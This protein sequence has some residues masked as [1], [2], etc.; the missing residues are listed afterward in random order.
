MIIVAILVI[1]IVIT[2]F[3]SGEKFFILQNTNLDSGN[4]SLETNIKRWEF[5]VRVMSDGKEVELIE[6]NT[7]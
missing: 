5:N 4:N 1:M 2:S 3:R 7:N 6:K